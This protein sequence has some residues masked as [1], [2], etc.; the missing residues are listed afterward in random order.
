MRSRYTVEF[1]AAIFMILG[2][3]ALVFL[4]FKATDMS[5]IG[6]EGS[7]MVE[8]RFSNIGSLREQAPVAMAGVTLGS[9]ADISLDPQTLE[10]VVM[11]E[12]S[13]R[14]DNLPNDTSASVLTQGVLGDRYVGL[15]PGGAPDPLRPGDEIL[16][17]QSAIVLE[18]LIGKY[19]FG[20]GQDKESEQ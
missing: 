1:T 11:L 16:I 20:S 12:I 13:N 10:A 14:F 2:V 8:A 19:V 4:A 17:T 9:V 6:T 18:E 5:G 3:L 7:Y 15:E